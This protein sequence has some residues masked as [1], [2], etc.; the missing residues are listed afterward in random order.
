M[1]TCVIHC[2]YWSNCILIC[3]LYPILGC[4]QPS[5]RKSWLDAGAAGCAQC[6]RYE[7]PVD[8]D[9]NMTAKNINAW[10]SMDTPYTAQKLRF[11][12]FWFPNSWFSRVHQSMSI[13]RNKNK[14]RLPHLQLGQVISSTLINEILD[15][16]FSTIFGWPLA[17]FIILYIRVELCRICIYI[18][19]NIYFYI[20]SCNISRYFSYSHNPTV[21]FHLLQSMLQ[22]LHFS[23]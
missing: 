20:D 12:W 1:P 21:H 4:F 13:N 8:F 9:V 18:I 16:T 2:M 6:P 14:I 5:L 11:P 15:L 17:S 23:I 22:S 3:I 10:T 19:Y 7:R